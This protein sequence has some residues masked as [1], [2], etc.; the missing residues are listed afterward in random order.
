MNTSDILP[1]H[2]SHPS[3]GSKLFEKYTIA[4]MRPVRTIPSPLPLVAL[5]QDPSNK[6]I[7]EIKHLVLSSFQLLQVLSLI[8]RAGD[9]YDL[10]FWSSFEYHLA[11]ITA[12]IP[13]IKPLYVKCVT[14]LFSLIRGNNPITTQEADDAFAAHQ[15][16][17]VQLEPKLPV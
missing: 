11:I 16:K 2:V 4:K 14:K 7:F 17:F 10:S 12:C 9:G 8:T 13:T 15:S 1:A 6:I 3:C 5:S